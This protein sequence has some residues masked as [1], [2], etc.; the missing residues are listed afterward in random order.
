MSMRRLQQGTTIIEVLGALSIATIMLMSLNL[1]IDAS[2]DDAKGQ[3]AAWHQA[4]AVN[5]ASKYITAHYDGSD[6]GESLVSQTSDG[7][8]VTVT[9][10]Q[11]KTGGFL[12]SSFSNTNAF[13]QTPCI[14]VRQSSPGKLDALVATY[15]GQ[16]IPD[17]DIPLVGMNAGQGGGYIS[18]AA[19]GTAR[20]ASWSLNTTAYR[21]AK[22]DGTT[23]LNGS[24]AN[25]GGH[26][27]SSLF[28]DGPGQLSTGF[29]YRNAVPGRPE[30][31]QMETPVHMVPGTGAQAVEGDDADPRCTVASGTGKIAVDA[32]GHILSC[33]SGVWKRQGSGFWKD[34]VLNYADLPATGNT[35]GDVH[36]VTA[37]NRAFT[38]GSKDGGLSY[39]WLPLAVDQD[40]D[41]AME[42]TMTA[43]LVKLNQIVVK[44]TPCA[45]NGLLARDAG[46]LILSCQ[47][48]S[49]RSPLEASLNN[50]AYLNSWNL[51]AGDC[52]QDVMID[53]ASLSGNRPL[54]LTGYATC[55]AAGTARAYAFVDMLDAA[56][57]TIAYAGGCLSQLD[58]A[59]IGVQNLGDIGL[60]KIPQ[61]ITQLH[62]HI[63]PGAAPNDFAHLLLRIYSE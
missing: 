9:V 32:S 14:L 52:V 21:G 37:L 31:N 27:V 5:A 23:V 56:G 33:Q 22:C 60:H 20:G 41:L 15:G 29:L 18:T 28:Y 51:S 3:Q 10:A 24:S 25:D 58:N 53:L 48:G 45:D 11:L 35:A 44:N 49:W 63:E 12:S 19:P 17:R 39:Y 40:G 43:S 16:A 36:M 61:N 2:L 4:Q 38:W 62:V 34:P 26:L 54:Y 55:R 47:S 8:V 59:G 46:G 6:G 1:M 57:N 42:G 30:L 7:S 13:N 50:L